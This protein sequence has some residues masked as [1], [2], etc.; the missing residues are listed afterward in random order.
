MRD[1]LGRALAVAGFAAE[2]AD[3]PRGA[4]TALRAA[5]FDVVVSD[6]RMPDGGGLSVL[7][8]VRSSGSAVPVVFM[9]GFSD[10]A[11]EKAFDSGAEAL[12]V[13]PFDLEALTDLIRRLLRPAA[14]RWRERCLESDMPALAR[15]F[16]SLSAAERGGAFR[17][18]RGGFFLSLHE[19][20]PSCHDPVRFK[21]TFAEGPVPQLEGAGIVRWVRHAPDGELP[22]GIGVEFTHLDEAS[23]RAQL[24]FQRQAFR[25]PFIPMGSPPARS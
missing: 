1:L 23:R 19:D 25:I 21:L 22:P 18:G 24:A 9:T 20:F 4:L 16:E 5:T 7:R 13:K 8:A 10:I 11:L 15:R 2:T 3:G 12:I 14:D 6:V 17:L